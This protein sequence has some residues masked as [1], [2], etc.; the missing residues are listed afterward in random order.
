MAAHWLDQHINVSGITNSIA[1]CCTPSSLVQDAKHAL[2]PAVHTIIQPVQNILDNTAKTV[3]N[4]QTTS[5]FGRM[6]FMGLGWG[7]LGWM[8]WNLFGAV[9]PQEKRALEE[10][11]GG[12]VKRMRRSL[13]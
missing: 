3:S 11:L 13:F 7:A 9:L 6:V 8:G 2:D 1:S 5:S 4:I 12:V 10:D